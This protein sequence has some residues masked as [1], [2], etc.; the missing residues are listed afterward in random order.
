MKS[1][2]AFVAMVAD[3]IDNL[4]LGTKYETCRGGPKLRHKIG[5][6]S[7]SQFRRLN[8]LIVAGRDLKILP[9]E[10]PLFSR[11]EQDELGKNIRA[12]GVLDN[13]EQVRETVLNNLRN[14]G[15]SAVL[16][17]TIMIKAAQIATEVV[18]LEELMSEL[19][20]G[21]GDV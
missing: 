4:L 17:E 19:E 6:E 7:K 15:F 8:E 5:F 20:E 11:R 14:R 16:L 3:A 12:L 1:D 2:E 10:T 21:E 13:T 18:T 9:A